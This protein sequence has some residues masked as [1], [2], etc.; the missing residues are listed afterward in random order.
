MYNKVK[1]LYKKP[2]KQYNPDL[3]GD[4]ATMQE[5]NKEYAFT[6]AKNDKRRNPIEEETESEILYSNLLNMVR[7]RSSTG[8]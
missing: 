8:Y 6:S 4:T 1:A 7:L 2:G 5:I 3:D